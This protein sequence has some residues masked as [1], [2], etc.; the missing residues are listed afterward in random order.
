M[1]S[2]LSEGDLDVRGHGEDPRLPL[3]SFLYFFSFFF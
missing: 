2:N 3:V 1:F